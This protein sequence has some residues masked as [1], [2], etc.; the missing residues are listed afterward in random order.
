M[1]LI[2]LW[3]YLFALPG[4]QLVEVVLPSCRHC[5]SRDVQVV[6]TLPV[7]SFLCRSCGKST[8]GNARAIEPVAVD[9]HVER[10]PRRRSHR[11]SFRDLGQFAIM[12]HAEPGDRIDQLGDQFIRGKLRREE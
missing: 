12:T 1:W 6:G 7:R 5:G 3:K 2:K 10:L 8:D 9:S 4:P 11:T